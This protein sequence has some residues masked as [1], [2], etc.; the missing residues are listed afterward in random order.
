MPSSRSC[1]ETA[2][3]SRLS[4]VDR[5]LAACPPRHDPDNLFQSMRPIERKN[6][7]IWNH[8][9]SWGFL[10]NPQ[11]G[12]F[13]DFVTTD[14]SANEDGSALNLLGFWAKEARVPRSVRSETVEFPCLISCL[15]WRFSHRLKTIETSSPYRTVLSLTL[16]AE[17]RNIPCRG[18]MQKPP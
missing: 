14:H 10:P 3:D 1:R 9:P 16:A 7:P 5:G 2:F 4:Q 11:N 13:H 17:H 12:L 6:G 8:S 18:D 15:T